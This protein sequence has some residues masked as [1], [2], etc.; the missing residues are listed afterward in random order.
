MNLVEQWKRIAGQT[1]HA[2]PPLPRQYYQTFVSTIEAPDGQV[3][4]A[5]GSYRRPGRTEEEQDRTTSRSR[6]R[7]PRRRIL[8]GSSV[9]V[10]VVAIVVGVVLA[11]TLGNHLLLPNIHSTIFFHLLAQKASQPTSDYYSGSASVRAKFDSLLFNPSSTLARNY[12]RQFCTLV[13]VLI[14]SSLCQTTSL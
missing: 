14:Q 1:A 6:W 12:K 11:V 13:S 10:V 4:Q 7:A 2:S 9:A 5:L 3:P 8:F